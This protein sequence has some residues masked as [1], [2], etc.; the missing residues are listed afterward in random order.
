MI[1]EIAFK[2]GS[3]RT[4][5]RCLAQT[6]NSKMK[7]K[8][9]INLTIFFI[10]VIVINSD[11][12]LNSPKGV[13]HYLWYQSKVQQSKCEFCATLTDMSKNQQFNLHSPT[14]VSTEGQ[15]VVTFLV[16][17]LLS[18]RSKRKNKFCLEEGWKPSL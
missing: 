7:K 13:T 8:R 4:P 18:S 1:Y 11:Q 17:S 12:T 10:A 14:R 3:F 5:I 16:T 6:N 9:E 15:C 2:V